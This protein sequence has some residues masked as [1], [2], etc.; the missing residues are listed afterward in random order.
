MFCF[1]Y[2]IARIRHRR[3]P[4]THYLPTLNAKRILRSY[5]ALFHCLTLEFGGASCRKCRG[6]SL[7]PVAERV[8]SKSRRICSGRR[9]ATAAATS[10]M[11]SLLTRQ[12]RPSFFSRAAPLLLF[13]K[14][15]S[16][17]ASAPSLIAVLLARSLS[18]SLLPARLQPGDLPVES[19]PVRRRP[20]ARP[21]AH[22][23][24]H[25]FEFLN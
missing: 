11:H 13:V 16:V 24:N 5:I 21:R 12:R 22:A 1:P 23:I 7:A 18:L 2:V 15:Q 19:A 20:S 14:N 17:S 8:H 3:R 6:S 9:G 4:F 10:F 25:S